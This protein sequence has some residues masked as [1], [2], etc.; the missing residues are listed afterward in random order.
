MG[1]SLYFLGLRFWNDRT[2]GLL[3]EM[4]EKGGLLAVPS[5]PSLGQAADDGLLMT[6]YRAADWSVVDG[7][8]VALILRMLGK[9]VVRISGL[10]LIEKSI[11]NGG[12][13]V[14]PM[15]ERKILWVVPNP[16]EEERIRFYMGGMGYDPDKQ[17]FYR[18]PFY[19]SDEEFDDETLKQQVREWQPDWIVLCLGGGRQEKLGYYLRRMNP[20][21]EAVAGGEVSEGRERGPV[22]MCTGAAIAFF[23]GGQAKIPVWADR[24]YLG[25]FCR[26]L[27]KPSAYIPRYV[28]AAWHFPMALIRERGRWFDIPAAR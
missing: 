16:E 27:E 7:G 3:Q 26:I 17:G 21:G 25:W 24:L 10:Q 2:E 22:I 9:E 6:A 4:D 1:K 5:A 12:T 15:K 19:R 28:K 23:T 11:A 20:G 8:Y 13:G 18:A 14:V